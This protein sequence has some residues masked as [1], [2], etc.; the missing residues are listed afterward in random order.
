MNGTKL[1][2]HTFMYVC[3]MV[4]SAVRDLLYPEKM[5]NQHHPLRHA[6]LDQPPAEAPAPST[7]SG[8]HFKRH[9]FR[10]CVFKSR[11][12]TL[13]H[14]SP[15]CPALPCPGAGEPAFGRIFYRPPTG[16]SINDTLWPIAANYG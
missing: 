15:E 12:C 10:D 7:R 5:T 14:G 1:Q 16:T 9:E 3:V 11:G 13:V 8:A 6:K 4:L 2:V